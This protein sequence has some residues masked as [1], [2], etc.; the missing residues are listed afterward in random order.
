M[1]VSRTHEKQDQSLYFMQVFQELG[2]IYDIGKR[3]WD[4][5]QIHGR[6][7]G[8]LDAYAARLCVVSRVGVCKRT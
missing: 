5:S 2:I 4:D 3:K 6:P 1:F 8:M 7:Y